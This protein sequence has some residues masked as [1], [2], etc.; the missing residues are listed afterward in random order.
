VKD[1]APL[2]ETLILL[3]NKPIVYLPLLA[4]TWS[5][6]AGAPWRDESATRLACPSYSPSSP[7]VTHLCHFSRK[8]TTFLTKTWRPRPTDGKS[9]DLA[10]IHTLLQSKVLNTIDL[11]F[12]NLQENHAKLTYQ[13][14]LGTWLE[15]GIFNSSYRL[16]HRCYKRISGTCSKKFKFWKLPLLS[17]KSVSCNDLCFPWAGI[18]FDLPKNGILKISWYLHVKQRPRPH[19]V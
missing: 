7:T 4:A 18:I 5:P 1:F 8:V 9:L 16:P 19:L 14:C 17:L 11:H 3:Q 6:V 10:H 13:E 2:T 12:T 15:C